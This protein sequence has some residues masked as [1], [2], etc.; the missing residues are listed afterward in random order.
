VVL[1]A[2]AG[3]L[4]CAELIEPYMR[5]RVVAPDQPLSKRSARVEKAAYER[6]AGSCSLASEERL[7]ASKG[8]DVSVEGLALLDG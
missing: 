2:R 6:L 5:C 7:T 1:E 4:P 8:H 3:S